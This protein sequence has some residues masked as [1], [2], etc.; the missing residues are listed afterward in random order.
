VNVSPFHSILSGSVRHLLRAETAT[1]H[2][3]VDACFSPLIGAGDSGYRQ[4]LLL[5][6]TALCPLEDG[7]TRAGVES[8][9]PDWRERSRVSAL[10]ADLSELGVP[11]PSFDRLLTLRG[12]A[13]IFGVIYVLEGSRL[14]AE[15]LARRISM[16][17][18]RMTPLPL[19]YLR[20]GEGRPF[21]RTFI[22]RLEVSDAVKR[23]P[24][25]AVA[26]A[27]IAFNSFVSAYRAA[28]PCRS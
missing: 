16:G 27:R 3:E 22:E 4:F 26:G 25:D 13:H 20:H 5:S 6:A 24:A 9:L 19:R 10:L 14:G 28:E 15:V 21:W 1:E 2:A 23:S 11:R 18:R 12:E 17:A 7:L 8:L